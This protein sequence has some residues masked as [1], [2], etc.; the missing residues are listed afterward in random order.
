[1]NW[2]GKV[3]LGV[4]IVGGITG[5]GD[6]V[7]IHGSVD[8]NGEPLAAGTIKFVP[9]E[10]IDG[11]AVATKIAD[12]EYAFSRSSG[13]IAGRY[14]VEIY[15]DDPVPEGL[16]DPEEFIRTEGAIGKES[17]TVAARFNK[18]TTLTIIVDPNGETRADFS[19]SDR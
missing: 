9:T 18:N 12:G 8:L 3:L 5:C 4:A 1:M 19:V 17:N 13:P 15:A 14:S 6:Y 16:D 2:V 11:G 7:P 10:G